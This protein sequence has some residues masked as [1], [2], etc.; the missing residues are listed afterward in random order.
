[1]T[2]KV[3]MFDFDGTLAD[4]LDTLVT[5]TN[6]LALEFGYKPTAP[7][8]L[9]QIRNLS[10]REIVMQSGISIFKIP[11]LLKKIKGNLH[12]EIQYLNSIP[13]IKEAL[14]QLK[15]EGNILGIL[16]SNS[17][18]NVRIF[19]N[20]QGMEELFSFVYSETTLFSK[21]KIIRKFMKENYLSSEEIVYVGDETR[22][23]ESSKK[24][25]IK[26]IAVSWGFNSR[27]VLAKHKP[28]FLIHKP[29]EL[30]EVMGSLQ[31]K[32]EKAHGF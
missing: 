4:T 22:D 3:I 12:N 7:E 21:H 19:L 9:A 25:P 31:K 16:T 29:S 15:Y 26:V 1:M 10:S 32:A 27:E 2:V 13:G 20:K 11:F 5:I 28:D 14:I 17:E 24:I 23:I 18:E 30:I 6:R 8:E